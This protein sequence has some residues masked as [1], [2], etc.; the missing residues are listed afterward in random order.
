MNVPQ[1]TKGLWSLRSHP[2]VTDHQ[3]WALFPLTT[4]S[5]CVLF[6]FFGKYNSCHHLSCNPCCSRESR[7]G[8]K[9]AKKDI[10]MWALRCLAIRCCLIGPPDQKQVESVS[11]SLKCR[12][13]TKMCS[14]KVR[15]CVGYNFLLPKGTAIWGIKTAGLINLIKP[16]LHIS[17][18]LGS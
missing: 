5:H 3:Y 9:P 4:L 16:L 2:Y 6:V 7:E 15:K 17:Y 8:T 10:S 11:A 12:R 18:H 1:L 13:H 14:F